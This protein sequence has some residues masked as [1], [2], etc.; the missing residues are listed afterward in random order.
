MRKGRHWRALLVAL[1]LCAAGPL[2]WSAPTPPVAKIG[3]IGTGHIGSALAKLWVRSGHRV[4]LSS[5]HPEQ[6]QPLAAELGT[7]ARVGTPRE[8]AEFGD[9]VLVS[10]PY[11]ALPELG[12]ELH[13]VLAGKIVLDTCNPYPER[14]GPMALE[15][16][17]V[18]TGVA[19]PRY[20]PGVR[21]V[22]AFNAIGFR[23]LAQ[24]SRRRGPLAAIPLAGDDAAA[25]AAAAQLVRDAGFEPVI[26]GGLERAREFDFGTYPYTHL[27]TGAQL[28]TALHLPA[29][30]A[31][32]G[33]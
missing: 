30:Q 13:E 19:S 12:R 9:V 10:V 2:A 26:V 20:L 16:R 27:L 14:D 3:I 28:R 23:E 7:R 31:A 22:R 29:S 18:G 5:R 21:L 4:L 1:S 17:Q 33:G 15:A 6:L 25:L 11:K 24:E 8:A 32:G